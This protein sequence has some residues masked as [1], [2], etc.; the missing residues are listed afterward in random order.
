MSLNKRIDGDERPGKGLYLDFYGFLEAPFAITPDPDF[1]F[2]SR[3]HQSVIEK[4]LYGINNRSGFLLLTGEVGTGKTTVCRTIL[5]RLDGKAETVYIINPSLSGIEILAAILDDL[6]IS[7]TAGASKKELMD[8][9]NA[10]LLGADRLKPVVIIIDDAQTMPAEALEDLRLLSNLET[11]KEKLLQMVIVGQPELLTTISKPELRQLRQRIAISCTLDYLRK[12]EV[13]GYIER[14]LFVAGNKGQVRFTRASVDRIFKASAG[15]PRLINRICDYS[16]IAGY[17]GNDHTIHERYVTQALSELGTPDPATLKV[18]AGKPYYLAVSAFLV[19]ALVLFSFY[20]G[21]LVSGGKEEPAA[22]AP[23]AKISPAL[24]SSPETPAAKNAAGGIPVDVVKA[25]VI[26]PVPELKDTEPAVKETIAKPESQPGSYTVLIASHR[27]PDNV[28]HEASRYRTNGVDSHW[29]KVDLGE[30]GIWYR[31]FAG[32]FN[33]KAEAQRF[34]T[35]SGLAGAIILAAP[36]AISVGDG[37]SSEEIGVLADTIRSNG[38]DCY[39]QKIKKGVH[40]LLIGAFVTREGAENA[41]RDISLPGIVP[42]IV[43]R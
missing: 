18:L 14:R 24:S 4:L 22:F 19:V 12:E 9:L 35:E 21:S 16:L 38:Y 20:L 10:F 43:L 42:E 32:R 41:L 26:L 17:L 23:A 29:V 27:S 37:I 15:T 6:R 39:A 11:D 33:S 30:D 2:L 34:I 13:P 5:D 1:L 25:P 31:H 28:L 8:R 36:W 40:R 7:F 3:T